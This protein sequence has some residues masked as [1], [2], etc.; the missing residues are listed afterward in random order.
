MKT[1][2]STRKIKTDLAESQ[3]GTFHPRSSHPS[4]GPAIWSS[5][6]PAQKLH[7]L[8]RAAGKVREDRSDRN[9]FVVFFFVEYVPDH[10]PCENHETIDVKMVAIR[11]LQVA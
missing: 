1:V 5:S 4:V 8:L 6:P 11:C 3:P 7:L 10:T 9:S 2:Y